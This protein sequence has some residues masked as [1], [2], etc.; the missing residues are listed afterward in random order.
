VTDGKH[1]EVAAEVPDDKRR[2]SAWSTIVVTLL[3]MMLLGLI[4]LLVWVA[5][6]V[7]EVREQVQAHTPTYEDRLLLGV[8][9]SA[10]QKLGPPEEAERKLGLYL[11]MPACVAP[12]R[13]VAVRMLGMCRTDSVIDTHI[14]LLDD[15]D[16]SVRLQA[17]L[18][19]ADYKSDARAVVPLSRVLKHDH[20]EMVRMVAATALGCIG[21]SACV[22]AL[23]VALS[24]DISLD[25]RA[26]AAYGLGKVADPGTVE[27]L[28]AAANGDTDRD[29]RQ[30]A[31][32]ALKKIKAKQ[33]QPKEPK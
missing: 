12:R 25:V 9:W 11:K 1:G 23:V 20:D 33:E 8:P 24:E 14:A 7:W 2:V 5:V 32:D 28:K 18:Y 26:S 30:A 22:A 13:D 29:V 17:T 10:V 6:P 21:D 31:V 4:F 27:H 15:S 3:A 16:P 19:F